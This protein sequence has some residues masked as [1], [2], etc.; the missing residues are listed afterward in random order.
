[1]VVTDEVLAIKI[2]I[3]EFKADMFY[4]KCGSGHESGVVEVIENVLLHGKK[5]C[6]QNLGLLGGA[7]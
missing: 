3:E 1:M 2:V 5:V 4:L 7:H 6:I